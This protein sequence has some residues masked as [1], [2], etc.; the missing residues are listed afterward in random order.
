M[1]EREAIVVLVSV[2][3]D[4]TGD[5]LARKLVAEGLAACVHQMPAGRSTYR[6]Q[7]AVEAAEEILLVIKTTRAAYPAL[8]AVVRDAH[9]YDVPEIL[10]LA[11]EEGLPAYVKWLVDSVTHGSKG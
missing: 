1:A 5:R 7:G 2:P 10:A 3:L 9:P 11:V 8:E 4:D 6:W